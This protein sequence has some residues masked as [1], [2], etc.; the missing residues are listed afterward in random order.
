M[1]L[2]RGPD[3]FVGRY[4]WKKQ[5]S[6]GCTKVSRQGLDS[7][8]HSPA[9]AKKG[10]GSPLSTS[11][12]FKC[13][14]FNYVLERVR[15]TF[16]HEL[17]DL[18][19]FIVSSIERI[20]VHPSDSCCPLKIDFRIFRIGTYES[21]ITRNRTS[22]RG[23]QLIKSFHGWNSRGKRSAR[24]FVSSRLWKKLRDW[25]TSRQRKAQKWR[26]V[27]TKLEAFHGP[28]DAGQLRLVRKSWSCKKEYPEQGS[29]RIERFHYY[30]RISMQ[31]QGPACSRL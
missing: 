6:V 12:L 10:R 28:V 30:W 3:N 14:R 2:S 13:T 21:N 29:W 27:G 23:F 11:S 9:R 20:F 1:N 31:T 22:S 8:V 24:V 5:P 17:L 4:S 26:N 18:D 19:G 7:F 16:K 15:L 25:R